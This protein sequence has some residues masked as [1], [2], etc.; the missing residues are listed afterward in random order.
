MNA[1]NKSL[2]ETY[3]PAQ[4]IWLR[5]VF[6][7]PLL[8][9]LLSRR[10]GFRVFT[11][12]R[13]GLQL[14]RVVLFAIQMTMALY[15][16]KILSLAEGQALLLT[17]PLFVTALSMPILGEHVG[18]AR[19]IAVVVG[20][21]GALI[22]VRPGMNAFQMIA[23]LGVLTA[24]LFAIVQIMTRVAGQADGAMTTLA[25]QVVGVS[26]VLGLAAPFYAVPIDPEDVPR[27]I[28]IAVF[29]AAGHYCLIAALS[30]AP[31][32]VIQPF[33]FTI[34]IYAT[35]IGYLVFGDIPDI[36]TVTGSLIIAVAGITAI[37]AEHGS[38][39]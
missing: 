9:L 4:V 6:T 12:R 23:L 26:I 14:A 35:I 34:L 5:F 39:R 2:A 1:F 11:T 25:L 31:A 7:I 13:P 29:G 3:P 37:R 10:H 15:V 33:T 17:A 16:F 36:P 18:R 22:I 8:A 19:W 27:F 21:V 20:F 32:V 30:I 38:K 28:A 24:F